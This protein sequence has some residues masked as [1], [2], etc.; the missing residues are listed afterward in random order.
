MFAPGPYGNMLNALSLSFDMVCHH[1]A[2]I[3]CWIHVRG[4]RH[5]VF[6][7]IRSP[8]SSTH[9]FA[10]RRYLF[11]MNT[12]K[13]SRNIKVFVI[14]C[15]LQE[16]SMNVIELTSNQKNWWL[17]GMQF[18]LACHILSI[19]MSIPQATFA[20]NRKKQ[21]YSVNLIRLL[22]ENLLCQQY[23]YQSRCSIRLYRVRF[24]WRWL[25][26]MESGSSDG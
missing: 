25:S 6:A 15:M 14:Y 9:T 18:H 26:K 12:H 17:I 2:P 5:H 23:F 3:P 4:S 16:N 19:E 13:S 20:C 22:L 24:D 8:P 10:Y 1:V 7:S 21:K 11:A